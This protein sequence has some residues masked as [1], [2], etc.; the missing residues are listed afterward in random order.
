L[1][2]CGLFVFYS[3]LFHSIVLT[4]TVRNSVSQSLTYR[5]SLKAY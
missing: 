3:I 2:I 5:Y 1:T 4:K